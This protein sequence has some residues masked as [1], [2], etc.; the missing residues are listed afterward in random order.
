[1]ADAT[2]DQAKWIE[3]TTGV[4]LNLLT[5]FEEPGILDEVYDIDGGNEFGPLP[6]TLVVMHRDEEE[7]KFVISYGI[8]QIPCPGLHT[9]KQVNE[10]VEFQREFPLRL[11][12]LT[13]EVFEDTM[14]NATGFIN[15]FV[16]S[17]Q[18]GE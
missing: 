10:M 11:S 4:K 13:R 15:L 16:E 12:S 6:L 3:E 17:A 7:P 2:S 1:M 8:T 9:S 18:T 5:T 14:R